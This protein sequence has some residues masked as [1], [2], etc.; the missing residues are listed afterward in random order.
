M[1]SLDTLDLSDVGLIK[2]RRI[3]MSKR[4]L[5]KKYEY[6]VIPW[7]V[8]RMIPTL[9]E[10]LLERAM[11]IGERKWVAYDPCDGKDGW[12]LIDDSERMLVEL[13]YQHI[14]EKYKL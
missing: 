10:G 3:E 6:E 9:P 4:E 12:L 2:T 7:A 13:T 1:V 11:E 8:F 5:L 14:K